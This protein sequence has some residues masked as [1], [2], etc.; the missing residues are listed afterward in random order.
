MSD[1]PSRLRVFL[2]ELRRRGVHRV[3]A[4]YF[5][6][7]A[8]L[9]T[10]AYIALPSLARVVA[11][12]LLA[13]FP[14]ALILAWLY[15]I[16]PE[17]VRRTAPLAQEARPA[18]GERVPLARRTTLAALAALVMLGAGWFVWRLWPRPSALASGVPVAVLPFRVTGPDRELW[19]EGMVDLL[20]TNLDGAAGL[21]AIDPRAILSRWRRDLGEGAEAPDREA[22]L[23][24]AQDVEATFALLGSAV[25]LG[26]EVR[27]TAQVYHVPTGELLGTEQVQ[28]SPDSVVTLVDRLS[29]QV[30]RAG[31]ARGSA[32]F[33]PL[34]LGHVTTTSLPALKAYLAGEQKF[35]R[36]RMQEAMVDFQRAV[37][38]DSTFALALS[39]LASTHLWESGGASPLAYEYFERAAR[40]AD[41]LPERGALLLRGYLDPP[42]TAI[43]TLE[44]LTARY[45][46]FAEGWWAL[47]DNY[48]HLGH[49]Q[50]G[51]HPLYPRDKFRNAFRR[52][53]ELDPS[54][55][56]A[57]VHLLDDAFDQGDSTTARKLIEGLRQIDPTSPQI[58]GR[59]LAYA[60]V[61]G[62]SSSQADARAA[63]D[64]ADAGVLKGAS[65]Q[66]LLA[67]DLSPQFQLISQ[68]LLDARHPPSAR[69]LGADGLLAAY[70][71]QGRLRDARSALQ[72][73]LAMLGEDSVSASRSYLFWHLAGYSD[74]SSARRAAVVLAS[75]PESEDRFL[76]GA[77]AAS[78]GRWSDAE[79]EI[80]ALESSARTGESA[81][82]S[83]RAKD[84]RA[85]A[86]ALRGYAGLRRGDH[87][88]A[89]KDFER[90]IPNLRNF[91]ALVRYELG[92]LWLEVGKPQE[93][94]RYFRSL[95]FPSFFPA[96]RGPAA[97]YLGDI[98][99]ALG[100][101]EEAKL[102]YARF[103][104]RWENCDPELRPLWD[105][106]RDAL[107]RLTRE[108]GT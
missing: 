77:F 33:A 6:F 46:D 62:D 15:E 57:Y 68:A 105:Q 58:I 1:F 17:G 84:A 80:L 97:F 67:S 12:V 19:R 74:S 71:T 108:A 61:W 93:A 94:E 32:E 55:G 31:L 7:A 52:A 63:L 39:R 60:L 65:W 70:L 59:G 106:A 25:A 79:K 102:Q 99:E 92:K 66:L 51:P 18:E 107:A 21:R 53:L 20:S 88:S 54:F 28:G 50:L 47:G 14:I 104:R 40:L 89:I 43:P 23:R 11:A 75:D 24:V 81:E 22:A 29:M 103:V 9:A 34:D 36:A 44:K 49:F 69:P 2:V 27:L 30:L 86:L 78:E 72:A 82:D 4:G 56:L 13:C 96:F 45:P 16:T 91:R 85:Y 8:A 95:E 10:V 42:L 48:F 87:Q 26:D 101:V 83:L 76:L 38:A 100:N 3:A 90:A 41:R 98:Y 37:D 73:G 5:V 35:R 64:T